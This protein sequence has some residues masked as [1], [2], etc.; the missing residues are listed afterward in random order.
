VWLDCF[1]PP[2]GSP[3]KIKCDALVRCIASSQ[4]YYASSWLL[5]IFFYPEVY[6]VGLL[7]V[8]NPCAYGLYATSKRRM[9]PEMGRR[10]GVTSHKCWVL[11]VYPVRETGGDPEGDS[12]V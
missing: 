7:Q 3:S 8:S 11:R 1:G 4:R 6:S 12:S 2:I 9:S 10:R 5:R